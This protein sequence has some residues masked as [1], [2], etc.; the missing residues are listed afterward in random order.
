MSRREDNNNRTEFTTE[1]MFYRNFLLANIQSLINFWQLMT[2]E[3]V[4]TQNK[5]NE[6]I[7]NSWNLQNEKERKIINKSTYFKWRILKIQN[8]HAVLVVVG[9]SALRGDLDEGL[10]PVGDP[11]MIGE[12]LNVDPLVGGG[13]QQTI[14]EVLVFAGHRRDAFLLQRRQAAINLG[15]QPSAT[16][17]RGR[18]LVAGT[19][20]RQAT[21]AHYV[22][23]DSSERNF[24]DSQI[25]SI[26]R[27]INSQ[28]T[29]NIDI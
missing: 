26:T 6:Q 9:R 11:R 2:I 15:H 7:F 24:V 21:G 3:I 13:H 27:I 5:D 28:C 22:Q 18:F 16:L 10:L 17:L 23:N 8:H 25:K 1:S 12:F 20:K 4:L 29:A 14:H 19:Q